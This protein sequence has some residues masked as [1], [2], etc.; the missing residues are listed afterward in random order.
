MNIANQPWD[1]SQDAR[2]SDMWSA[3]TVLGVIALRLGRTSDAVANRANRLGLARRVDPVR[4][5]TDQRV[6]QVRTM[7][8]AGQ[9][10]SQIAKALGGG[11]TRN[12]VI[13]KVHRLGMSQEGRATVAKP[14]PDMRK[15]IFA[16]PKVR[17]THIKP[18]KPGPQN[19]GAVQHGKGCDFSDNPKLAEA[20][21]AQYRKDGLTS[22]ERVETGAGVESPFARPWMEDRKP[23]ECNWTLGPRY[24]IKACCNPVKARGWCEGHLAV[25]IA[26]EQPRALRP[27]DS[28][29][30]TRHDRTEPARTVRAANDRTLWDDARAAA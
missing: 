12:A 21:R 4:G 5:W 2:L 27:N 29:G 22:L 8:A 23:N 30:L 25:G 3:G 11:L 14:A 10:A 6:E 1:Q 7:W 15:R 9:S 28:R 17:R 20:K 24:Q 16:A 19:K 26:P 13:G 18:P